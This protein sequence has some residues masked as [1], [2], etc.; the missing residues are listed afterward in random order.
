[1]VEPKLEWDS[2]GL[3]YHMITYEAHMRNYNVGHAPQM[4]EIDDSVLMFD[5]LLI[6]YR[7]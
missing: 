4:C 2:A 6:Q 3:L 7:F 5:L 1:M